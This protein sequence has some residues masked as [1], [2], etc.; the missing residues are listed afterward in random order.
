MSYP[1]YTQDTPP[2]HGAQSG[3]GDQSD[4]DQSGS[5]TDHAA[6]AAEQGKQA[7]GEVAQ[8]AT[9]RAVEVKDE[10]V[11]QARDLAGEARSQLAGQATQQHRA[12]V[13]NLRNLS[14]ELDRMSRSSDESGIATELASRAQ[15]H[16]STLADWLDSREPTQ[17]LGEVRDFARQRPG[18]FLIGALAAG[19]VAG[20]L[21]RGAVQVHTGDDTAGAASNGG[22]AAQAASSASAPQSETAYSPPENSTPSYSTPSYSTPSYGAPQTGSAL[23]P[24]TQSEQTQAFPGNGSWQ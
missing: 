20:R 4:P 3:Y 2:A 5:M 19:V 8:S 1:Q 6:Q 10:A 12:L 18:T 21:A 15:Q 14:G 17:I 24:P 23:P 22:S 9:E 11:R 16:T 7:V 13:D